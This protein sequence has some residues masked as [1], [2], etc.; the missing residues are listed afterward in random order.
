MAIA[1]VQAATVNLSG[2]TTATTA[3]LTV[4]AGHLLIAD[5][6]ASISNGADLAASPISDSQAQ[7]WVNS[8]G[9]ISGSPF[10]SNTHEKYVQ[11]AAAGSTTFT[12]TLAGGG[13]GRITVAEFS[14]QANPALDKTGGGQQS[15]NSGT[16]TAPASGT[17]AQAAEMVYVTV[18]NRAL[19]GFVTYSNLAPAAWQSASFVSDSS[20]VIGMIAVYDIVSSTASVQASFDAN[21]SDG[22]VSTL[23]SWK[24][25]AGGGGT[26]FN[27]T[28]AAATLPVS[29]LRR[30]IGK[31]LAASCTPGKTLARAMAK[32]VAAAC[33]ALA[34]LG[35][36]KVVLKAL[37]AACHAVA[38][39]R[40]S[41]GKTV[42]ASTS[43]AAM[44]GRAVATF[45]TALVR[46]R[47]SVA[48]EGGTR[49]G[50]GVIVPGGEG[51]GGP[52]VIVPG[53]EGSGGI[54]VIVPG[55]GP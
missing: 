43:P 4:T 39:L 34:T 29:T 3:A 15:I 7:T 40:R 27:Q 20:G 14:G 48:S 16:N 31:P 28:V 50:V 42:F 21:L 32:P 35:V 38:S 54:T 6:N 1:L 52:T 49:A 18:C 25:A 47:A 26:V 45:L 12:M 37:D 36:L 53:L 8:T 19:N 10:G 51:P 17:L 2:G 11:A 44:L 46:P 24:A 23:S 55:T 9:K 30:A 13:Y 5:A 41:A 33:H 22:G